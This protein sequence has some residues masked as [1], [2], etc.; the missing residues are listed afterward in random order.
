MAS[1]ARKESLTIPKEGP[2]TLPAYQF[3]LAVPE[4]P[5]GG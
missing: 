1:M 2:R 3:A 4:I 5:G